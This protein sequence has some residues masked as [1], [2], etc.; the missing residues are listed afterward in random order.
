[1]KYILTALLFL[2]SFIVIAQESDK[3][4]LAAS[5][6]K[7]AELASNGQQIWKEKIYG[8]TLFVDPNSRLTFANEPDSAGILKAEGSIFSGTLPKEVTIA[9]TS[10]SWQGKM[11]SVILWPL[12][13][14]RDERINLIV[15]E[16][17][18]RIQRKLGFPERSPTVDHLGSLNGRIYFL[19]ELQAL[20]AALLKPINQRATDLQNAIAFRNKRQALFPKT[21]NN[22]QILEMSEGLAEFTGVILGRHKDNIRQHLMKEIDTAGNRKS[23]IRSAAYLTGPIYGYLLYEKDR[24]W[25][26]TVDSNSNFPE[27]LAKF[28]Q[29]SPKQFSANAFAQLEKKYDNGLISK[30]QVKEKQ[31]QELAKAYIKR[32]MEQPA[33]SITLVKM[34]IQF[35][36]NNLFDLGQYGTVYPT[37]NIKDNWGNLTVSSGGML[38]KNWHIVYLPLHNFKMDGLIITGEGWEIF[39]NEGWKM[40]KI[41][42]LNYVLEKE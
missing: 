3:L 34:N 30:E 25:T 23:L 36:P 7:E 19:L 22:E 2:S 16:S 21:F 13:V 20:K 26:K 32:F 17:F 14:D 27:L 41:D 12:S 37:A 31:R 28:Y 6:L 39:L 8:P 42:E 38:M 15:H 10:I 29:L 4:K 40:K 24:Y 9:N 18:H 33:L 5:Y 11:W 35:N 1:M